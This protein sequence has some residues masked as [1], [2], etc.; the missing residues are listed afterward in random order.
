MRSVEATGNISVPVTHVEQSPPKSS[1]FMTNDLSWGNQEPEPKVFV[2]KWDVPESS[3]LLNIRECVAFADN[4]T[5]PGRKQM[6]DEMPADQLMDELNIV[7]AHQ[8]TLVAQLKGRYNGECSQSRQKD[9]E[10]ALLK[11]QLADAR[12]EVESVKSYAHKLA[13]EKMS[14]L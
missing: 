2:P 14:L 6:L 3:W 11:A 8:A 5:P 10:I 13:E 4:V 7:T 9:E 1:P 12:I